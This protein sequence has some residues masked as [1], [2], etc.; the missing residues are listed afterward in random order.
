MYRFEKFP[1]Q[2]P[3][4]EYTKQQ[5]DFVAFLQ[6]FPEVVSLYSIGELGLFWVSDLDYLIIY[7]ED[8]DKNKISDFIKTHHLIDT[9]LFLDI[10]HIDTKNYLS[11]HFHYVLVYGKDLNLKFDADNINLNII[12]AWKVCFISLLRNF[13]CYQ[14]TQKI[15]VKNILSQIND[16][17]YPIY[18]L[19]NLWITKEEY[20]LFL[21][22]FSQYRTSYFMHEDSQKLEWYLERSIDI[23]WDI[24]YEL[25]KF[26]PKNKE[27]TFFYGRFPTIFQ[28]FENVEAYRKNTEKKLKYI[29]KFSRFLSLPAWYDFR[30]WS[31]NIQK[32]L[33]KIVRNNPSF[34]NVSL[35]TIQWKI[36]LQIKKLFD[37]I[38]L[39]IL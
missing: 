30:C 17:R 19:K 5:Q 36:L 6:N 10:E 11:H 21:Q 38:L 32:D 23:S 7:R 16:I 1:T 22:D 20:E 15:Q 12:Y 18:F 25:W 28:D 2:I 31:W 9:I 34:L 8:I 26:L 24:I 37:Y 35:P 27:K 29:W 4:S 13:Y 39:K 33:E 3:E 14:Y